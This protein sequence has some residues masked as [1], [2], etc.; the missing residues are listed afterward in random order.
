MP[1]TL[2]AKNKIFAAVVVWMAV[3][4]VMFGSLFNL[5]DNSNARAV[6]ELSDRRKVL[7]NLKIEQESYRLAS[8]D[9]EQLALQEHQPE[10][11]FSRDVALV[12]EI[13]TLEFL[14]QK[15]GVALTLSGL[16][17]TVNKAPRANTATKIATVP[18][19]IG[20]KGPFDRVVAYIEV[21]EHLSFITSVS[22]LNVT[23]LSNN[24]ISAVLNASF[25][26][27]Q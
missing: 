20:L 7:Q 9:I 21:M 1:N 18:Y 15:T 26:L 19:T 6:I 22:T 23:A 4:G 10:N 14:A 24:N 17:G 25:Y 8:A 13:E 16:F 2:S 27:R 12:K 3:S 11:F 5:L